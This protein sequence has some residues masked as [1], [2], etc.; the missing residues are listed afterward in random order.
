MN[1]DPIRI[2]IHNT[3]FKFNDYNDNTN[4]SAFFQSSTTHGKHGTH[5]TYLIIILRFTAELV[6]CRKQVVSFFLSFL[7]YHK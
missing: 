6:V 7:E 3:A 2:R 4:D 1:T 5:G